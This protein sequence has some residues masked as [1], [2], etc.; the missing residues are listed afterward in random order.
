MDNFRRHVVSDDRGQLVPVF[1]V[2]VV[3]A[4][5]VALA[6][7][8]VGVAANDRARAQAAADA[9]ALAAAASGDPE[10]DTIASANGAE[11]RSIS[12]VGNDVT[13]V[14]RVGSADAT[15]SA[16]RQGVGP[17]SSS[18]G[19]AGLHPDLAAAIARAESLLGRPLRITSGLR[20]R[21]EQEELWRNR[22]R[23]RYPVA[24]PGTSAHER[25]LAVDVSVLDLAALVP[26]ATRAGLCRPLP[27]AD[28]VHFRLC[29]HP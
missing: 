11:V 4:F 29:T 10:A 6:A 2:I 20:S 17:G 27:T 16:R 19:T 13:V 26:I 7:V 3:V 24:R 22:G 14:V 15:A 23:N 12:S 25:G 28:P 1:G 18:A 9:T 21:V 5:V 8:R